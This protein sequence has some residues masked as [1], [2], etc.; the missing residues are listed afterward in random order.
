LY[1]LDNPLN[2]VDPLGTNFW[3]IVGSLVTGAVIGMAGAVVVA[4]VAS[5]VAAIGVPVIAVTIGLAAVA[6]VGVLM[7]GYDVYTS[8]HCHNWDKVA[9]D[10]GL[11]GG[12]ALAGGM[13]L[14]RAMQF[15][16]TGVP[17]Q[18]PESW[19]PFIDTS[20][21]IRNIPGGSVAQAIAKGP[22]PSS[23]G[24]SAM[25]ISSGAFSLAPIG[26][27]PDKCCSGKCCP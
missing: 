3:S 11:L 22:T 9:F 27:S 6:A 10:A 4:V 2:S 7:T 25:A 21:G 20:F 26:S 17:S 19:N 23:A 5:G 13:G 1:C 24:Y 12:G 18:V 14:G 8:A 15:G 16:I